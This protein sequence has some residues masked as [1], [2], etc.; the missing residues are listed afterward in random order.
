MAEISDVLI[1]GAGQAGAYA[2]IALRQQGF[3]GSIM[4]VGEEAC[5]PYERPPLSKEYFNG[6][7]SF[8][9]ILIKPENFW[10]ERGIKCLTR[11]R[12]VEVNP[13][14]HSVMTDKGEALFYGKCIWAAG[15][16][17]RRLNCPGSDLQNIYSFRTRDD[18]DAILAQLENV[19]SVVIIGGGYIGLESAAAL[20][21]KGK[22]VTLLE[23]G[24]RVLSRVAGE[25]VSD[26]FETLHRSKGVDIRLGAGISHFTG[27]TKI[28]AVCLSNSDEIPC[29]MVIVGIGIIPSVTPLLEAGAKGGNGV[30]INAQCQTSLPDIYAIGDCALHYSR[31]ANGSAIRLESVQNANDQAIV[32]ARNIVGK[33][34]SYEALP[35]FWSN[36]YDVKLQTVGLSMGYDKTFIKG[37]PRKNSFSVF[38]LRDGYTIAID[39][40]N[41]PKDFVQGRKLIL[42][43]FEETYD[44][45]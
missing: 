23:A 11:Q 29:E 34:M 4:L 33:S 41:A 1:V 28:E 17:P 6:D 22:K 3:E 38:Y 45:A 32:A 44:Y 9:R 39:C 5:L 25:E 7:K 40:I 36:Q 2:A 30:E 13:D 37:D 27:K 31:F 14:K 42:K 15:G 19:Q 24:S 43:K 10:H 18:A 16:A 12:V 35:W 21:K 20:V 26:Y 8:E